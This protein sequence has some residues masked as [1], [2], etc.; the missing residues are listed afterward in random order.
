MNQTTTTITTNPIARAIRLYVG[1]YLGISLGAL[2]VLA[3][4]HGNHHQASQEAW[5]HGIIVATTSLLMATF[6]RGTIRGNG[7]MY[8]RLRITSTVMVV[9]IAVTSAIPGD[10]PVWMKAEQIVCGLLLV[11]LIVALNRRPA[12]TFFSTK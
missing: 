7:N 8:L 2:L 5:V 6:A 11:G 4:L 3:A 10:F 9:A 1:S 12:K